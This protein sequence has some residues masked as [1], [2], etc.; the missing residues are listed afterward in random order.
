MNSNSPAPQVSSK[1]LCPVRC[2]EVLCRALAKELCLQYCRGF[3]DFALGDKK[4][5]QSKI[6]YYIKHNHRR[7]MAIAKELLQ[8]HNDGSQRPGTDSRRNPQRQPGSLH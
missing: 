5:S 4:I 2:T 1:P 7:W 3:N 6:E 8:R